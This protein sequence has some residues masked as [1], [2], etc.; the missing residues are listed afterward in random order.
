LNF[1]PVQC[2]QCRTLTQYNWQPARSTCTHATSCV[3][4]CFTKVGEK[5]SGQMRILEASERMLGICMCVLGV[6]HKSG[7]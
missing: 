1:L 5:C 2:P 7:I 3:R 6:R 4:E